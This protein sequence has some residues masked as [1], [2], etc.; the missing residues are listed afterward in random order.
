M[1]RKEEDRGRGRGG[2]GGGGRDMGETLPTPPK[3]A[4]KNGALFIALRL[5]EKVSPRKNKICEKF[6]V[7]VG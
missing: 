7:A 4:D 2:E 5:Q 1:S 3:N 6:K